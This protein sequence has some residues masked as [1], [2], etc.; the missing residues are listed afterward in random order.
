MS[1]AWSDHDAT[2]LPLTVQLSSKCEG[3]W[4]R[5]K[6]SIETMINVSVGGGAQVLD[7]WILT[8]ILMCFEVVRKKKSRLFI[9]SL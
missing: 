8:K 2:R 6:V 4:V 9:S 5:I 3:Q 7:S 1:G